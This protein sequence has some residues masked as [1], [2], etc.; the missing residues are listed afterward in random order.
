MHQTKRRIFEKSMELFA[1]K[2]Y[3]L[4]S[5]EEITS[6]V[7]IAKGTFYYHFSK[8]EDIF[9]FLIEEGM[10]LLRNSIE[11][12]IKKQNNSIEK[13]KSIILIQIKVTIKYE[14]FIRF[15]LGE[16]WGSEERNK[17]C[18]KWLEEYIQIIEDIVIDGMNKKEINIGNSRVIA[19][20]IFNV[21]F[22]CLLYKD[23]NE[24]SIN[25]LYKDFCDYILKTLK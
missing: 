4:T 20:G 17:V 22:S 13:I 21:I 12:K 1:N 2:G 16:M 15:I 10:N 11:I 23:K 3:D 8:K 18:R 24:Y 14:N 19:Y 5:I 6:V 9:Y 25:Q 7:G